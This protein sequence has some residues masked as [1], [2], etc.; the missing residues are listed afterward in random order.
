MSFGPLGTYWARGNIRECRN[1]VPDV[2]AVTYRGNGVF[3][4]AQSSL[5]STGLIG[6]FPI[7]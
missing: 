5:P 6:S 2:L 1:A 4:D 3:G 7:S